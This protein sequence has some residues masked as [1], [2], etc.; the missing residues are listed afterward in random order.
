[1]T[2]TPG[3]ANDVDV[4]RIPIEQVQVG[5]SLLVDEGQGP[6]LVRVENVRFRSIQGSDGSW[7][8]TYLLIVELLEGGNPRNIEFVAGTQVSRV[9]GPSRS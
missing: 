3:D 5:Y 2:E 7:V 1:M 6:Q 4:Q 8:G 9:P